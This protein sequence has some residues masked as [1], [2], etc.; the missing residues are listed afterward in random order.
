M[1]SKLFGGPFGGPGSSTE[2]EAVVSKPG[3]ESEPSE[4]HAQPYSLLNYD[5]GE[6]ES[7]TLTISSTIFRVSY[8]RLMNARDQDFLFPVSS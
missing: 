6:L 3:A 1:T 7:F 2:L 4:N 5:F 8:Y